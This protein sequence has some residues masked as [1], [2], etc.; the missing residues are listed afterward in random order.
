MSLI[1]TIK[2]NLV[3]IPGWRT[4]RK[5][6]VFESDDWGSIRMPS[7]GINKELKSKGILVDNNDGWQLDILETN[8]DLEN[9]FTVLS[10]YKDL[11]KKHPVFTF[12]TVMGN[13]DFKKIKESNYNKY[14]H[15]YFFDTYLKNSGKDLK[16]LWD[17]AMNQGLIRPQF[18]AREHLNIGLWL[19][20][21]KNNIKETRIAFNYGFFGLLAQTS[22][23]FQNHYLAAYRAETPEE[24][25]LI[26]EITKQG[27]DL[28]KKT[29]GFSSKSFIPCN[30]ILPKEL[31]EVVYNKGVMHIQSQRGQIQPDPY[32]NGK[33]KTVRRYTGKKNS[34]GQVY[35]VR[36][37]K[38]E[39]F[40]NKNMDWVNHVLKEI[41]TSFFWNKPAIIST[42]RINFVGGIDI[43]HRDRNLKQLDTLIKRIL[44]QWPD[45]EFMSSDELGIEINGSQLN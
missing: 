17:K 44:K 40:V 37:V 27:L 1:N 12:N 38:F 36:N 18:H 24:L 21:L 35:T 8:T 15:E 43:K 39:P 32:N 42:H 23:K 14:Y 5:I 10:T 11:N 3:N 19:K 26:K 41:K 45:V 28:F 9:L 25:E 2:Q 30:Y 13:P 34:L 6:V 20:D 22:S 16:P 29:F 33:V 4:N 31:E 7:K